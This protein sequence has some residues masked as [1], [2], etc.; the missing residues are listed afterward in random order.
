MRVLLDEC[1]PH[2]LKQELKGHEVA[3]VPEMGWSGRSNGELIRLAGNSF[4]VFLTVDQ[5]IWSQ[6]NLSGARIAVVTLIA[7]SNRLESLLPLLPHVQRAL[8]KI[9]PGNFIRIRLSS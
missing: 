9:C 4:D 7:D 6:Q 8:E 1:L 5:N 3:T 2:K